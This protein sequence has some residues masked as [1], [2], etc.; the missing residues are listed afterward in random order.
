MARVSVIGLGSM[1]SALA[2]AFVRA[3]NELTV[4]NRDQHKAEALVKA[5][6]V[7]APDVAA[8]VAASPV[9]V[10]CLDSYLSTRSLL[11]GDAARKVLSGRVVAELGTGTPDESR[12]AQR[13]FHDQGALY[14]DGAILN[15]TGA[16][17]TPNATLLYSGDRVAYDAHEALFKALGAAT[18]FVGEA[19]G[20][21]SVLDLAWLSRIAAEYVGIYHGA[22]ICRSEGVDVSLFQS[23]FPAGDSTHFWLDPVLRNDFSGATAPVSVWK[24][25][26][27]RI[28]AQA[29]EAGISPDVPDFLAGILARTEAAG[30]GDER[31]GAMTKVMGRAG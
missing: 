31:V 4:W 11:Q 16:I 24:K 3:G 14:L 30:F 2:H 8:A 20:T 27:L 17:G 23:V 5:G 26:V 10:L 22:V 25:A 15:G 29:R 13:W 21:A 28:G 9:S 7:L 12:A 6:A 19:V 1:G 18:R